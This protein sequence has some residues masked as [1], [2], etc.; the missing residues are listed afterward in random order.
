G[1]TGARVAA[2]GLRRRPAAA[3]RAF[4]LQAPAFG[5]PGS[6]PFA[7]ALRMLRIAVA[8]EDVVLHP[9]GAALLSSHRTLLI[10]DAHFGKAVSFRKLGVPVPHGT[11]TETL[12]AL[13]RA[14][15]DTGA[16]RLVFLGDFLH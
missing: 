3:L 14:L 11:T 5:T 1:C 16:D 12:A 9:S 15:A 4:G 10:A 2:D 13:D 8:G 7:H 6:L